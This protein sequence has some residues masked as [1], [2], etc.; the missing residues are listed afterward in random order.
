[1]KQIEQIKKRKAD[2]NLLKRLK[3]AVWIISGVVLGLV[4]L[5]RQVKIPLPDYI[6]L[7]FLPPFHAILNSLAAVSLV[8]ALVAIK[9]GNAFVHQK[10]IYCAM[11]C[12]FVFLLSYVAYHFTTPETIYGDQ[13]GDGKLSQL[14]VD[15]A[16]VMRKVYLSILL[17]HIAL[18]ALSLPFILLNFCYGFTNHFEKHRKLSKKI[19]PVLLYVA[20]TG[21][22]V[23]V[24][25][26]P[27]Y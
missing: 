18:A 20:V 6:S 17:S 14:E 22:V 26:N 10:W 3:I 19:F 25:L 15:E 16:G 8:M 21:P 12:S 23:D 24:L 13:N 27:Y 1:M 11:A 5:M 2:S 7:N 4:M 9:K